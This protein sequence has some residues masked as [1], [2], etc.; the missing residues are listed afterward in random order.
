MN[1]IERAKSYISSKPGTVK[2]FCA[3]NKASGKTVF[4]FYTEQAMIELIDSKSNVFDY[5]EDGLRWAGRMV[6]KHDSH[7]E[8]GTLTIDTAWNKFQVNAKGFMSDDQETLVC[9]ALNVGGA[10]TT[11]RNDINGVMA[12]LKSL[13]WEWTGKNHR[14]GVHDIHATDAQGVEYWIEVKGVRGRIFYS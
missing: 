5:R 6:N 1:N 12:K 14:R 9:A 10:W 4:T 8:I 13:T 11:H 2:I 3:A 7:K